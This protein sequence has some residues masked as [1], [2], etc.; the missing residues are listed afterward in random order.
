[1]VLPKLKKH[2]EWWRQHPRMPEFKLFRTLRDCS[3]PKIL[4]H[5]EFCKV[6]VDCKGDEWGARSA[7]TDDVFV[8]VGLT[9]LWII[10]TPQRLWWS[11]C[12][13]WQTGSS[14]IPM[15][16]SNNP[17]TKLRARSKGKGM[18]KWSFGRNGKN[19][20]KR[21]SRE[22]NLVPSANV[23]GALSLSYWDRWHHQ[24][25]CSKFYPVCLHFTALA[26]S[27]THRLTYFA[28]ATRHSRH[29][30]SCTD[31]KIIET[32]MTSVWRESCHHEFKMA[33]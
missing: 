28:R 4:L 30:A 17:V 29:S 14:N 23:A 3:L 10:S 16:T 2:M 1:M 6:T 5:W 24:R 26:S 7:T 19:I 11:W 8:K 15:T 20:A 9:K 18:E 21:P 25:V 31:W 27:D 32:T 12:L 22:S 13:S 33:D